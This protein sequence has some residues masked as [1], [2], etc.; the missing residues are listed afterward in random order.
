M[1][2]LHLA[3]LA[4]LLGGTVAG[5]R[6]KFD[7]S[8]ATPEGKL[9][10]QAH[11]E[12]DESR[13]VTLFEE[14]VKTYPKHGGVAWA[15]SQLQPIYLKLQQ[16]DKSIQAA[17]VALPLDPPN[18]NIAY[19]ALQGC[20][21]KA[22]PA[23]VKDWSARTVESARK[24]LAIKAPDNAEE[25][26]TW[27]R[28][29]DYATQVITRCEYSLYATALQSTDPAVI[30]DLGSALE[31]RHP[32]S[33]YIPQLAGRYVVA[34]QQTGQKEKAVAAAEKALS[35]EKT[36]EDLMMVAA[37]GYLQGRQDMGKAIQYADMLIA[38]MQSKPAPQGVAPE[39]WE[40]KKTTMLGLGHW[41]KG[42]AYQ[43]TQNYAET[44]KSFRAALPFI[45]SNNDLLA[46][47]YFY[48]GVANHGLS[49][50]AKDPKLKAE[51][52]RFSDLCTKIPGPY[53]QPCAKNLTAIKQGK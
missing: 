17:E 38:T 27:T 3:V 5:Q 4:V 37:D 51:A 9:L 15:Y 34:L 32:E 28:E 19:N 11:S 42:M 7:L 23:C 12:N 20:E 40:K 46:P 21:K 47:A 8:P 25:K 13:K 2:T 39:A 48:L 16:W 1:R 14:F 45:E 31:T 22:D 30:V 41:M 10:Q 35:M 44:D 6:P 33:Q 36:N 52:I 18:S 43:E 29:Q 53:Q 49:K 24:M 50:T 26:E